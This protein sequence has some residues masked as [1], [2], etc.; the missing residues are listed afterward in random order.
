VPPSSLPEDATPS[1][2]VVGH[3]SASFTLDTYVHLLPDDLSE[4]LDLEAELGGTPAIPV[5]L[6]SAL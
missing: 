6:A 1:R 3:H 4:A 2:Y 5:P